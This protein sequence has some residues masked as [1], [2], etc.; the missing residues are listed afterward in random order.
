ME[1]SL[2]I[3]ISQTIVLIADNLKDAKE[4]VPDLQVATHKDG[5][6]INYN[7]TKIEMVEK[8]GYLGHELRIH[9]DN[10]TCEL[11]KRTSL[12]WVV[13]GKMKDYSRPIS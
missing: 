10:Q 7:K 8:Y 6:N 12:G 1:K 9:R 2:A 3:Y 11:A 4:I 5:L 13:Y